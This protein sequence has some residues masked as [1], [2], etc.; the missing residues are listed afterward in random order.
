M[1]E[2]LK[3]RG[4]IRIENDF[5]F[6]TYFHC[7]TGEYSALMFCI[8]K[9]DPLRETEFGEIIFPAS[10]LLELIGDK[11]KKC[12]GAYVYLRDL[13]ERM[14]GKSIKFRKGYAIT[15]NEGKKLQLAGGVN[16]FEHFII[17]KEENGET[18][19]H[20]RFSSMLTTVLLD[21]KQ[22]LCLDL[23]EINSMGSGHSKHLYTILKSYRESKRKY[24]RVS[25][26]KIEVDELKK[27][28]G[29]DKQ[30]DDYKFFNFHVLKDST[31]R[32]HQSE[33]TQIEISYKGIR[34]G[35]KIKFIEFEIRDKNPVLN[36]DEKPTSKQVD[37]LTFAQKKGYE[38]LINFGVHEGIA[39]RQ[40]ISSIS[41]SEFDGFEDY[42]VKYAMEHFR[43]TARVKKPA[44][45]V[46]WWHDKKIFDMGSDV[47][48]R[49]LERVVEEKRK[50]EVE[51]IA[52]YENRLVAKDM[53]YTA[54]LKWFS[55]ENSEKV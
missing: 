25:R 14:L 48:G 49:I 5:L 53:T 30:Y 18:N 11:N 7:H 9:L 15:N 44:V 37:Q 1:I 47:W 26:Y 2:Q 39:Y 17:S 13:A 12:G 43:K 52:A 54:F 4:L 3:N 29:L 6:N 45:L 31:Q 27:M 51:D 28:L 38:L 23:D 21:L 32:I 19:V 24:E 46:N 16:W 40:L 10:E 8:S 42:F 41:G 20:V 36:I 35:R 34:E 22:Y 33:Y 55:E 50:M